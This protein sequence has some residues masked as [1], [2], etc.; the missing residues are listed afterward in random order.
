MGPGA[1]F[2]GEDQNTVPD[3]KGH[4]G[5]LSGNAVNG[6]VTLMIAS[7]DWKPT[8]AR[9]V[10]ENV[11]MTKTGLP[12]GID[13]VDITVSESLFGNVQLRLARLSVKSHKLPYAKARF[14]FSAL[15]ANDQT[16]PIILRMI[17][18]VIIHEKHGGA[19]WTGFMRL[20]QC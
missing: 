19:G 16:A 20:L 10:S 13:R 11:A 9:H 4:K 7:L 6:S 2:L 18:D 14:P 17:N 8:I 15:A 1:T 5:H 12:H 3:A